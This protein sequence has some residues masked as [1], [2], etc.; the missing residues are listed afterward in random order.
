MSQN[1]AYK[2]RVLQI[3]TIRSLYDKGK[4]HTVD[5]YAIEDMHV[6]AGLLKLY[7]RELDP[8]LLTYDLYES[9]V[10]S[11]VRWYRTNRILRTPLTLH[12]C[13]HNPKPYTLYP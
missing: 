2:Q 6:V 5:L 10:G 7:F 9:F 12:C 8:P 1:P 3:K 11:Q 13:F 4:G